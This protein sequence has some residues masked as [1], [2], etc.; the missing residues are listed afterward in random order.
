[1]TKKQVEGETATT[2]K[3]GN[4]SLPTHTVIWT[5][6]MSISPFYRHNATQFSFDEKK[7]VAVDQYLQVDPHVFVAGDNASTKYVGLA[8]TAVHNAAAIAKNIRRLSSGK[9]AKPYKPFK[10]VSAV[11]LGRNRAIIQYGP[12]TFDGVIGGLIR[13][14]ADLV[15]YA[16]IM[17]YIPALKL[18]LKKES[19]E[20]TCKVCRS[21][22]ATLEQ[23]D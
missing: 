14:I 6:G 22:Q 15:G 19:Y 12:I 9:K 7:R 16:D 23:A 13:R 11:P 18:W 2:L 4:R 5:A 20:E 1:M 17:G 3:V 10:P 21:P 8:L